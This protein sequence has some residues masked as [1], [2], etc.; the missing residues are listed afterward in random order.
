MELHMRSSSVFL[1]GWTSVLG[2]AL[3]AKTVLA[4]ELIA[5]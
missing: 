2:V 3:D 4:A 1:V 5:I